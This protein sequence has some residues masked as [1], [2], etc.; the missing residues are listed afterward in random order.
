MGL[1]PPAPVR[2]CQSETPVMA[3]IFDVAWITLAAW[4]MMLPRARFGEVAMKIKSTVIVAIAFIVVFVSI[5]RVGGA[6][7]RAQNAEVSTSDPGF[8]PSTG[9]I[10]RGNF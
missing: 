10:S 7:E 5:A 1:G 2:T 8:D 6:P 3:N 4:Q 9:Q